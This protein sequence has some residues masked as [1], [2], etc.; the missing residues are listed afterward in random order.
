MVIWWWSVQA[1]TCRHAEVKINVVVFDGSFLKEDK[2][3]KTQGINNFR[4]RITYFCWKIMCVPSMRNCFCDLDEW[5]PEIRE[6]SKIVVFVELDKN[7]PPAGPEFNVVERTQDPSHYTFWTEYTN[8]GNKWIFSPYVLWMLSLK[9][10]SR[11]VFEIIDVK[12]RQTFGLRPI[13]NNLFLRNSSVKSVCITTPLNKAQLR[14]CHHLDQH[15]F[16]NKYL[17][18][19]LLLIDT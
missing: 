1:E 19:V 13:S 11:T 6:F 15:A 9:L 2:S 10:K 14:L 12:W 8:F 7:E 3:N 5:N 16:A 17:F 18:P 4:I